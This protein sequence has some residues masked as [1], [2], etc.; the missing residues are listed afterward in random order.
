MKRHTGVLKNSASLFFPLSTPEHL[1][2]D[3]VPVNVDR[4]AHLPAKLS[5]HFYDD[6]AWN[7]C[8]SN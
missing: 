8:F 6:F 1:D 5:A 3:C 7:D 4:A 2:F